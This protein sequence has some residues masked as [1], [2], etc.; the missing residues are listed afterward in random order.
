MRV[1]ASERYLDELDRDSGAQSGVSSRLLVAEPVAAGRPACASSA[2]GAHVRLPKCGRLRAP[3][4]ARGRPPAVRR[5][6]RAADGVPRE[7]LVHCPLPMRQLLAA[8]VSC[9]CC[10]SSRRCCVPPGDRSQRLVGEPRPAH[11]RWRRCCGSWRCAARAS[12]LLPEIAGA[13]G[14]PR[15]AGRRP[16]GAA[17]VGRLAAGRGRPPAAA[18]H[19]AARDRRLARLRPRDARRGC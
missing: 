11:R 1:S 4:R 13:G 8:A 3:R 16:V 15:G 18:G 14:L 17:D 12:E 5:H 6:G 19:A 9:A 2:D 10:T 7:R